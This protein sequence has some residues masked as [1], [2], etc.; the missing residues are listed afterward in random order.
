M[1][2]RV[3]SGTQLDGTVVVVV[4]VA[5]VVTVLGNLHLLMDVAAV[6]LVAVLVFVAVVVVG[7][8]LLVVLMCRCAV[9]LVRCVV[10]R[11][12]HELLLEPKKKT[13][14]PSQHGM[15]K[16]RRIC[17]NSCHGQSRSTALAVSLVAHARVAKVE[18][19]VMS[20]KDVTKH[21]HCV[22]TL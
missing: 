11:A 14:S 22:G 5:G 8:W 20:S 17:T 16:S 21:S 7:C 19:I 3:R 6:V 12:V 13:C 10:A 9:M 4:A 2:E 15:N 1:R 18:N